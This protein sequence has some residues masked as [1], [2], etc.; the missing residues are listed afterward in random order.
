M[1]L[2]AQRETSTSPIITGTS[3]SGPMTAANAAPL[4]I[5]KV[6]TAT[7]I[8]SSKLLEAAVNDN[9]RQIMRKLFHPNRR[10]NTQPPIPRVSTAVTANGHKSDVSRSRPMP[11][12]YTRRDIS[13]M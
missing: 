5:P 10:L 4:S 3:I 1:A 11:S 7:A 13:I 9:N 6:A 2:W 12:R 8:A